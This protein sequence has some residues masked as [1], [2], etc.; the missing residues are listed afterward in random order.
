MMMCIERL[1]KT[2]ITSSLPDSLDPLQFDYRPNRSADDGISLTLHTAPSHLDQRDTYVRILFID[3]SSVFN[4]TVPSKLVTKLRDLGLNTA[5][6]DCSTAIVKSAD[7]TTIYL[8]SILIFY[9]SVLYVIL[10]ILFLHFELLHYIISR[11]LSSPFTCVIFFLYIS[12][13]CCRSLRIK[14]F[15]ASDCFHVVVVHMTVKIL[16]EM[17]TCLQG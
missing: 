1:V 7:D 12:E 17:F 11:V 3:Y 4:T 9:F 8:Y 2:F 14:N 5:L 16:N 10:Y 6:C 13:H 15:S